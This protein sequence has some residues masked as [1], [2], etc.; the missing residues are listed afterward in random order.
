MK[1]KIDEVE[2]LGPTLMTKKRATSNDPVTE[3]FREGFFDSHV[4]ESYQKEYANSRPYKHAVIRNLI[5]DGLLRSVRTEIRENLHFSPKETDIYK[6]HQSG[7]LAN[8][9]GLDDSSLSRI[10]SLL[11]LRDALYSV[12]F[13]EELTKITGS[14]PLSGR[15]TDMAI[16][17]YTPG[18]Y[19]L[20]HDDVIGSR[21]VSYILYLTDPDKPWKAEWGGALRLYD[22]TCVEDDGQVTRIPDPEPTLS[23][24]P[25]FNQLS[26][27][28][29]QPG[30]SFHDVEEVY[31]CESGAVGEEQKG[32]DGERV[33]MAI[34][35]WF[36]IPQ[37]GE[38]GYIEGLEEEL[39]EKSSLV[40]LQGKDDRF[41]LPQPQVHHYAGAVRD[42]SDL[43]SK[44]KEAATHLE[45]EDLTEAELDLLIKYI[46]PTYLTPDTL[47]EMCG[48]FTD[49]SSLKIE[50]FLSPKFSAR[51]KAYVEK[52][53]QLKPLPKDAS[54]IELNTDWRVARPP[55]KHRFLYQQATEGEARTDK[56]PLRELYED[57]F[58]SNAFRKWLS[59]ATSLTLNSYNV[60]ARRFR[61]G[62]DYC[63]A[64][65]YGEGGARIELTL[66]ITPIG[67]WGEDEETD[68][69]VVANG[70]DV[71]ESKVEKPDVGGYEI[72]YAEDDEEEEE[73]D[74]NGEGAAGKGEK[75][76]RKKTKSDPAI[77][78]SSPA[79]EDETN[80][81]F[82][83]PATW[84]SLSIVLR[85]QG[86][87]RFVKYVS[88]R[89]P[90]DRWD[91]TGEWVVA[92]EEEECGDGGSDCC[93]HGNHGSH[94]VNGPDEEDG[95]S[96][97]E[98][99][100]ESAGSD[101][102]EEEEE[103]EYDESD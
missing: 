5:S 90:G 16:N 94:G 79:D 55:H 37:E 52:E 29:V 76:R 3:N 80:V 23:I 30:Q 50:G 93:G 36:H 46:A 8:L 85:D 17:V 73:D 27:F 59:I 38:E 48:V 67:G 98:V 91:V 88:H 28:A 96:G 45:D 51:L 2:G 11:K 57:L 81:L 101:G 43:S 78:K 32:G 64:T 72:Y 56:T 102:V 12:K 83:S 40:Q 14:G 20:C 53:D 41:D 71:K 100:E 103:E 25:S 19:L 33:R 63:L 77:Y 92:E 69:G 10:P 54:A 74:G 66:G 65:G 82:S 22:T 13:R 31:A 39:A 70:K 15:R 4:L 35:G 47:E 1:R 84:N 18:S 6:I 61:R 68:E 97:D 75:Q 44:D 34:S 49:E 21:R 87:L 99:G 42:K 26:F 58:P 89:A 24:P 62:K 60:L 9:D 95:E 86:V 7:D